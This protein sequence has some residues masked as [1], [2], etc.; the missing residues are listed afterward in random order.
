[1]GNNVV[2]LVVNERRVATKLNW[3]LKSN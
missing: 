1:M 3:W 2:N